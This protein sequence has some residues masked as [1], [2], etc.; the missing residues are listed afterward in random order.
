MEKKPYTISEIIR[1]LQR[2]QIESNQDLPVRKLTSTKD[3]PVIL[4]A[5]PVILVDEENK[6]FVS[7]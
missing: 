5:W 3:K 2:L 7:F 6:P 1:E 4:N